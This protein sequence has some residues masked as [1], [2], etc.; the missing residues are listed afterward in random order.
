MTASASTSV[1]QDFKIKSEDIVRCRYSVA[2]HGRE[3]LVVRSG[4]RLEI[5]QRS[6][7]TPIG[8]ITL[9]SPRSGAIWESGECIGEYFVDENDEYVITPIIEDRKQSSMIRK[10]N[11]LLYLLASLRKVT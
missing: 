1:S 6:M 11:P 3:F 8:H 4:G 10:I 5:R 9:G 2:F 7:E